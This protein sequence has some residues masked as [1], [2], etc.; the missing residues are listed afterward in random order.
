[1]CASSVSDAGVLTPGRGARCRAVLG[2]PSGPLAPGG[3]DFARRAYFEQLGA[4]GFAFGR[5]R[6]ADLP[7]PPAWTRSAAACA[8]RRCAAILPPQSWRRR[9]AAAGR[10]RRR[11]SPAI[12]RRSMPKPTRRCAIPGLGHLLS[13]SGIHM[14]VVGGLVFAR[15]AVDAF[16]DRADRVALAGQEARRASARWSRS[17]RIWSS[18]AQACR[19]CARS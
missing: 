7:A 17:R 16:A 13:V 11:W 10:S 5:C 9:R 8:S 4:T 12:A 14:G 3:Y 18:P 1:M 2:P 15:V 19:R 6:P